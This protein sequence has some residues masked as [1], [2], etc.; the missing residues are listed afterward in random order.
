MNPQ[1]ITIAKAALVVLFAVENVSL[2]YAAWPTAHGS[3]SNT[4]FARVDTKAAT[5]PTVA[6]NV[7]N[8]APGSNPVTAADGTVYIGNL[9]G[10]LIALHPDGSPYWRFKLNPEAGSIFSSP[11]VGGDGS[12][13]VVSTAI[14]GGTN[15][16]HASFLHK[17]LP[18]GVWAFTTL[19]PKS[20][21][22][23][24][25]DGGASAA[26]PNVW[27]LG[28]REAII[29][30]VVY[31]GLGRSEVR[32]IAFSTA[33]G[34]IADKRVTI[35]VYDINGSAPILQ[36]VIDFFDHLATNF[37]GAAPL[38][39]PLPEAGWPQPGVAIWEGTSYVW[40]ADGIRGTVAYIF[41]P[42]SGFTEILRYNDS[43]DRLSSPPVVLDNVPA[44]VVG[45]Q[46][47]YLEILPQNFSI[48]FADAITAAPTRM[49]NNL[50]AVIARSGQV[51]VINGSLAVGLPLNGPSIASA[52]ASCTH[53]F[54]SSTNE[55]A[56]FDMKTLTKIARFQWTDGG[57]NAPIIGPLGHVYAI[58]GSELFVFA[59][60]QRAPFPFGTQTACA[61][62]VS[63]GGVVAFP[64]TL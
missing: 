37:G 41:D 45:T 40:V 24:F 58:A 7:G 25:T 43:A 14:L 34:V 9:A 64:G 22:Y 27:A 17:F 15:P 20:T 26:P 10:E 44:A 3:P 63:G 4:G 21:I 49:A 62:P 29:V 60:L 39:L 12:I 1:R 16:I 8:I 6:V 36:A 50:L 57:R 46:N 18:G 42:A 28:G 48:S 52:A 19:F 35:Q 5:S 13:Y 59:P 55:L 33:D 30:P 47:G 56:T 31:K 2:S 54:V 61:P 38:S 51:I 23:P 11:A 53:L 32:V